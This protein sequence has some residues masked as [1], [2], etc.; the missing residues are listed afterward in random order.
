MILHSIYYLDSHVSGLPSYE[1]SPT[2]Q[3][4][5]VYLAEELHVVSSFISSRA[6][7]EARETIIKG[8]VIPTF[9]VSDHPLDSE[10]NIS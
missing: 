4:L 6:I 3:N 2:D 7:T 10:F 8:R 1:R 5:S 9:S